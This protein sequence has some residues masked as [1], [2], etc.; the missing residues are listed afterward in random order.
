MK[1]NAANYALNG[2]AAESPTAQ[3]L[4][5]AMR[6]GGT[7]GN[8][9]G[10][11]MDI[12]NAFPIVFFVESPASITFACSENNSPMIRACYCVCVHFF[13]LKK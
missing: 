6:E 11:T 1:Q 10:T 12:Y 9:G 2:N 8:T 3:S 4:T 13:E 5:A 7:L